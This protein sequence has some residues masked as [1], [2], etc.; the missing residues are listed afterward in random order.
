MPLF[1]LIENRVEDPLLLAL[2][3]AA[4][5]LSVALEGE[6]ALEARR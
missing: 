1:W 2:I 3:S 5:A 6:A 4:A